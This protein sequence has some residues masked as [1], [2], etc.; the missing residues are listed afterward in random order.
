MLLL[1]TLVFV[2]DA[3]VLIVD[4]EDDFDVDVGSSLKYVWL[5]LLLELALLLV[6]PDLGTLG[7]TYRYVELEKLS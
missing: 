4:D 5:L 7:L 2:G 6:E 3:L 1:S